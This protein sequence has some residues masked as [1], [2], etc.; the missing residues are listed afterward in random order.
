VQKLHATIAHET[1]ALTASRFISHVLRYRRDLVIIGH[2]TPRLLV[3][4]HIA[5]F[6]KMKEPVMFK[7]LMCMVAVLCLQASKSR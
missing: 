7:K 2:R 1:T 6:L 5:W 3:E 4:T